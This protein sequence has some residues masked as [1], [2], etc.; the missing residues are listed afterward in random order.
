MTSFHKKDLDSLVS[1]LA[2][3]YA[4]H[5]QSIDR[6]EDHLIVPIAQIPRQ[7]L[8][9]RTECTFAFNECFGTDLLQ[10]HMVFSDD[11]RLDRFGSILKV[12][13]TDH[14]LLGAATEWMADSVIGILDHHKDEHRY[15]E[16]CMIRE[17]VPVG[18]ATTLVAEYFIKHNLV[19]DP[20]LI[21]L[22]LAP[23]LLDTLN[24]GEVD[25]SRVTERDKAVARTLMDMLSS[26]PETALDQRSYYL[27]IERAKFSIS[28][29]SSFDLL[30]KDYKMWKV[31]GFAMGISSVGMS[32]DSWME[33]EGFSVFES[34][35]IKYQQ[36][37]GL[38]LL[39]VMTAFEEKTTGNF[40]RELAILFQSNEPRVAESK[41][42]ILEKLSASPELVL[43]RMGIESDTLMYFAQL[44]T[45]A[46]R[47]MV[48]PVME[49]ILLSIQH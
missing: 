46:T 23:I 17:I 16:Q 20:F 36:D 25:D 30:R 31:N 41:S 10:K 33:R 43:Q 11:L 2:F 3:A 6:Q 1:S 32:L 35:V 37:L 5:Q 27:A 7:D 45:K 24:L 19:M 9:L 39:L 29:L 12:I 42:E 13:L 4:W 47:K 38:N 34:Q 8:P 48:Q 49:R 28:H 21:R 26:H 14:N 18:S 22:M 44:N 40:K 15:V